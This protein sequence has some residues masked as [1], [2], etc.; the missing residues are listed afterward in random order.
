MIHTSITSSHQHSRHTPPLSAVSAS[1]GCR[2][3]LVL[4]PL[5]AVAAAGRAPA[6]VQ[7][8]RGFAAVSACKQVQSAGRRA[9]KRALGRRAAHRPA[10]TEPHSCCSGFES[11][12]YR[13]GETITR[14]QCKMGPNC[15]ALATHRQ[16]ARPPCWT[17][18]LP[19]HCIAIAIAIVRFPGNETESEMFWPELQLQTERCCTLHCTAM[20]CRCPQPIVLTQNSAACCASRP[21]S[22][23]RAANC[24]AASATARYSSGFCTHALTSCPFKPCSWS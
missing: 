4:P 6:A 1:A 12:L 13:D 10:A 9:A 17:D 2:H 14:L 3:P 7:P 24:S 11:H 19:L 18:P 15:S 23:G 21:R 20:R 22:W 8:G 16:R 5:L